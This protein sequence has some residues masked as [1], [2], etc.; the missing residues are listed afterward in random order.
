M[1]TPGNDDNFNFEHSSLRINIECAFG[2]LIR[3]WGIPWKPLEM[4]FDKRAAVLGA[5]I[6]L[7]NF[8]IERRQ[9]IEHDLLTMNGVLE[10]SPGSSALAPMISENGV[11]IDNLQRE[12]NCGNCSSGIVR[13]NVITNTSRRSQ[14]EE[15]IKKEG[16]IRP[17]R[18]N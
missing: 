11:P 6:R 10:V 3:R 13:K 7:H 16:L 18:K 17:Y 14:L 15:L 12:C 8:C 2:E 9:K 4:A 5:C 1:V